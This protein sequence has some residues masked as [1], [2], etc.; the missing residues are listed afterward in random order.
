M[1]YLVVGS[2]MKAFKRF[3]GSAIVALAVAGGLAVSG[4]HNEEQL[5][6]VSFLSWR[7]APYGIQTWSLDTG[8]FN[9]DGRA[10][11]VIMDGAIVVLLFGNG[12][13]DFSAP[14]VRRRGGSSAQQ[15]IARDLNGDGHLDVAVAYASGDVWIYAGDGAGGLTDGNP[16]GTGGNPTAL[17]AADIERD[18]D[19]D[20][21]VALASGHAQLMRNNGGIFSREGPPV[22]VGPLPRRITSGDFDGNGFPDVAVTN[23]FGKTANVLFGDGTGH[24]DYRLTLTTTPASVFPS[25][26]PIAAGDV[27]GDGLDDL[28]VGNGLFDAPLARR[29]ERDNAIFPFGNG[30]LF[31]S[32]GNQG[33]QEPIFL[34]LDNAP[35][36]VRFVDV[37]GDGRVDI[38]S[39]GF[40]GIL[41]LLNRET[42]FSKH[43][44]APVHI[45]AAAMA[46]ED[47]NSDGRLDFV[48]GGLAPRVDVFLQ[49]AD[50]QFAVPFVI[51]TEQDPDAEERFFQPIQAEV[52]DVNGDGILDI[53]TTTGQGNTIVSFLGDGSGDFGRPLSTDVGRQTSWFA[54][55]DF[56]GDGI[57][58]VAVNT[59]EVGGHP[60]ELLAGEGT[61]LFVPLRRVA[62]SET[63]LGQVVVG[64]FNGDEVP[65]LAAIARRFSTNTAG[66]DVFLNDGEG[67]F[68][69]S[70]AV[71][72][73]DSPVYLSVGDFDGDGNSDL[74]IVNG[75]QVSAFL[76][77]GDGTFGEEIRTGSPTDG[78]IDSVALADFDEDGWV[79]LALSQS[80]GRRS[81]PFGNFWL[82]GDGR[83]GFR[84]PIFLTPEHAGL[85]TQG[86]F[87]GEM[88]AADFNDDG[89]Q[90]IA[91]ASSN[92]ITVFQG[93]GK[94]AF[95]RSPYF[96]MITVGCLPGC[97]PAAAD[98]NHDGLTDV[99]IPH[100]GSTPTGQSAV[101]LTLLFNTTRPAFSECA[102][103]CDGNGEVTIDELLR[104]VNIAL[105]AASSDTCVAAEVFADGRV[106]V[107]DLVEAVDSALRGCPRARQLRN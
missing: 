102:G 30:A 57:L 50:G 88:V 16:V 41:T 75:R 72:V 36:D 62:S 51:V 101:A 74:L 103:D 93:N 3:A 38:V 54:V 6:P 71:A 99:V 81:G 22:A 33:F 97:R 98:L 90:D 67:G 14:L 58:D 87:I 8:D 104:G 64:D 92:G 59:H 94:G 63:E 35:R 10:D 76:G 42:G 106:T 9:E 60:V 105:Q 21:V 55:A 23:E 83:G 25:P 17:V 40:F 34:P 4:P 5:P 31:L 26:F 45:G 52:A 18:G 19:L 73:T 78:G 84:D 37:N 48:L 32:A 61:G 100:T 1:E 24:F 13:G 70:A 56:T 89:H 7:Q 68:R 44:S 28:L 49:R 39:G 77:R 43:G 86:P 29:R 2:S 69:E 95:V 85:D 46:V 65:D 47:F 20:L 11:L 82:R 12:E 96:T 107:D 15:A 66:A 27:N 91:V 53:V 79:D 80:G